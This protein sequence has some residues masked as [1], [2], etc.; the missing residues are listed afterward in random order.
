M[1]IVNIVIILLISAYLVYKAFGKSNDKEDYVQFKGYQLKVEQDL[2]YDIKENEILIMNQ[3]EKWN[4]LI[5]IMGDPVN[6]VFANETRM[7]DILRYKGYEVNELAI[8]NFEGQK[9]ITLEMQMNEKSVIEHTLIGYYKPN[10]NS[11]SEIIVTDIENGI[12]F[13]YDA[14]ERVVKILHNAKYN[15]EEDQK[16]HYRSLTFEGTLK[17]MEEEQNNEG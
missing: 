8:Q 3:K 9:Y 17:A 1:Y 2:S 5:T 14:F 15:Q 11:I 16:Y 13:R 10:E 7:Q 12:E 6:V 4:A